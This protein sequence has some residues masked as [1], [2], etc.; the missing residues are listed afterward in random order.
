[1]DNYAFFIIIGILLFLFFILKFFYKPIKWILKF[2]INGLLGVTLLYLSNKLCG[3][4]GW[5]IGINWYSIGCCGILGLPGF[6]LIILLK[7]TILG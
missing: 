2:L 1:M 7:L 3:N 6:I 5:H 4:L